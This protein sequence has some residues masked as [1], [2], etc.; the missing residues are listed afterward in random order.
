M[1]TPRQ[2]FLP[3]HQPPGCLIHST[4]LHE[5][6]PFV[7]SQVLVSA[8]GKVRSG[9]VAVLMCSI[10]F[11][12]D[13]GHQIGLTGWSGVLSVLAQYQADHVYNSK[14]T[15]EAITAIRSGQANYASDRD[16][17]GSSVPVIW[18]P[19]LAL[20]A[21]VSS[22]NTI[23]GACICLVTCSI[24]LKA[25][26]HKLL[27]YGFSDSDVLSRAIILLAM[28]VLYPLTYRIFF[29]FAYVNM[30]S[31]SFIMFVRNTTFRIL[32]LF[33]YQVVFLMFVLM[34]IIFTAKRYSWDPSPTSTLLTAKWMFA[35]WSSISSI[36]LFVE[37]NGYRST[38][39][40]DD[41]H[42]PYTLSGWSHRQQGGNKA[43]RYIVEYGS[44][45]VGGEST[46]GDDTKWSN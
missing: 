12:V 39:K 24:L 45:A 13:K 26:L 3:F 40:V 18:F 37:N 9:I 41:K 7:I 42:E 15:V 2:S 23:L 35:W 4:L 25:H 22:S 21:E 6:T 14:A 19:L 17:P 11:L 43:S 32:Y 31:Q 28:V 8:A 20:A 46:L 5:W 10:I 36:Y 29:Y 38:S 16:L 27:G 30:I 44:E 1:Y 34:E 33:L